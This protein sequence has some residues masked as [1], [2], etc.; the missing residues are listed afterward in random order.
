[1]EK[2]GDIVPGVTPPEAIA[3]KKRVEDIKQ[4][5][6]P[7]VNKTA[8]ADA[9]EMQINELDADFR[10]AAAEKNAAALQ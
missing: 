5:F 7:F 6:L 2:R 8:A 4:R 3:C 9:A 10:K 1:M